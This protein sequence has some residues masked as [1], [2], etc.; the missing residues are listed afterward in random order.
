[1]PGAAFLANDR[2]TLRTVERDDCA[3]LTEHKNDERIRRP[4][5]WPYPANETQMEEFFENVLSDDDGVSLLICIDDDDPV[6][7]V[8]VSVEDERTRWGDLGVWVVPEQW[9]EG[10]ATAAAE[11][12]VDYAF[13]ERNLH[14]LLARV[15]ATN[16]A[17]R[18]IWEKLGFTHEGTLREEE[19]DD[20]EYVDMHYYGLLED[21]WLDGDGV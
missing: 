12:V 18:R 21:E 14:R 3:F 8:S 7:L 20:G 13:A 6:G 16:E 11:L 2:V 5:A 15:L 9:G 19:F 17:S 4:L 1:M 10:Y